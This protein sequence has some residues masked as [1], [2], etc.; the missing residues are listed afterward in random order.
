MPIKGTLLVEGTYT[1]QYGDAVSGYEMWKLSKLAHGGMLFTTQR[2]VTQPQ[3]AIW[4][5]TF[6]ITQHWAP[7]RL[8]LRVDVEGRT[9]ISEQSGTETQ[10]LARVETRGK[11]PREYALDSDSSREIVCASPVL[12]TVTLMRLGLQVGQSREVNAIVIDPLTLEP[13]ALKQTWLCVGDEKIE[14]AAGK[15]SAWL[16]TIR[17]ADTAVEDRLWADR[18]GV[19]LRYEAAQGEG[20]RLTRYRRIERRSERR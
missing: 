20:T 2:E 14:I 6:E 18:Q 15:F 17:T 10:W 12:G 7:T 4:S 9:L 11:P 16:Y 8:S 3:P 13:R 1:V 5:M 19:V